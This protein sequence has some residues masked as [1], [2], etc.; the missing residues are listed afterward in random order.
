MDRRLQVFC[1]NSRSYLA[2]CSLLM[3]HFRFPL[4]TA[5]FISILLQCSLPFFVTSSDRMF[6][7]LFPAVYLLR[8][9]CSERNKTNS[10]DDEK[11]NNKLAN[12]IEIFLMLLH[13]WNMFPKPN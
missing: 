2:F 11:T 5:F 9:Q 7:A 13:Q 8:F 3:Y 12:L 4:W 1:N 10:R 6:Y